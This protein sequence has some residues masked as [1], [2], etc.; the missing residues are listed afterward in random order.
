M[1]NYKYIVDA[2]EFYVAHGFERLEVP[3]LVTD[4]AYE[5]TSPPERKKMK[6]PLGN[7]VASGEQ[8][9]IMLMGENALPHGQFQTI[10]PCFRDEHT[11][12]SLHLNHFMKLE[13]IDASID[14]SVNNL[15]RVIGSALEFFQRYL[16]K[17]FV[18][19]LGNGTFDIMSPDAVELGSYGI[20]RIKGIRPFVYGTGLA[21]PR[22]STVLS[23]GSIIKLSAY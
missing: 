18:M 13:L 6:T 14:C 17:A 22:L 11:L 4:W 12:D 10:S 9:F 19:A 7:V 21:E 1:I 23:R 16:P 8:S 15:E 20:R 3:W 5:A 2:E